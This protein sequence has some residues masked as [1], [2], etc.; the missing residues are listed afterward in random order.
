MT[1][2]GHIPTS[3]NPR[4]RVRSD[5]NTMGGYTASRGFNPR[6]RVRSDDITFG[7]DD[8]ATVSIHAPG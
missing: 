7:N 1:V 6:S 4:S 3:F 8:M 5:T 2:A